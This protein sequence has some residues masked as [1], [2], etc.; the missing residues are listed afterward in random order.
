MTQ[1][2]VTAKIIK[3]GCNPKEAQQ[4]VNKHFEYAVRKYSTIKK[5]CE[6]IITLD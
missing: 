4:M 5:V 1:E 3:W 6:C 2:K